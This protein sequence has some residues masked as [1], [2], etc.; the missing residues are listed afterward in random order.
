MKVHDGYVY[1]LEYQ[2]K[3]VMR[4]RTDGTGAPEQIATTDPNPFAL[5]VDASGV[6]R[7]SS[8]A[9]QT[10]AEG[11]L[12]RA[13]LTPGGK[14]TVMMKNVRNTYDL[15]ADGEAIYVSLVGAQLGQGKIQRIA[16][17]K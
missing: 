14:T 7:A 9:A 10:G 3:L 16:K 15:A 17:V 8:G 12:A 6:Y 2:A 11:S 4:V 5:V 1:W 13:P